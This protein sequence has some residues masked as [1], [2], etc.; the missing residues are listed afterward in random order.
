LNIHEYQAAELFAKYGLPV[1]PG[2]VARSPAEA[3]EHARFFGGPVAVKAQVHSGGRGKAGGIKLAKTPEEAERVAGQILGLDIRGHTVH[4]LLVVP[5]V[6]IAREYYLGVVLDRE[7]RGVTVMGSAEGGVEIEEVARQAPEKIV[8]VL[9]DPLLGLQDYQAR[10][11]AYGLGLDG[12]QVKDFTAIVKALYRA[13]VGE[14]A[15]LAEI[16]PL[17]Q[18]QDGKWLALDSKMVLDDSGLY[19]HPGIEQLRD[20][21]E[22]NATELEARAAGLSFVKL[23]GNVGCVVNGAGLSMATMDAIKLNGG[24]PAN[25]LDVGGGASAQQVATALRLVLSDPNVR[26]VLFNIF[27][28]IARCDVIAAGL[29]QGARQVGVTVP[30][31]VRLRGTNEEEGRRI[32]QESGINLTT[33]YTMDEAA[34]AAVAA[35]K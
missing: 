28:G 7:R 35:A 14:D 30:L 24:E 34:R 6:A 11:L 16:N 2:K 33:A 19:R 23:E 25:F 4:Q 5:A 32:L 12:A 18:A 15:S 31:V 1:N 22:E 20:P 17:I 10:E 3:A 21:A 9:A 8:R 29:V 13:F 27:G 26:A